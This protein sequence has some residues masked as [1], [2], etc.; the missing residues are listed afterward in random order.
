MLLKSLPI[1][2]ANFLL[3]Q[4]F[5]SL[6]NP[7]INTV[8]AKNIVIKK[9]KSFPDHYQ[10][11]ESEIQNMLNIAKKN[12]YEL[13]TTEKD[14]YRVRKFKFDKMNYLKVKLEINDKEK[15]V[16]KIINYYDQN[17]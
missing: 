16:N 9:N 14:F 7:H 17:H 8:V 13:V 10:Y 1:R 6:I 15:L 2:A 4:A 3:S 11:K 5:R 12:N